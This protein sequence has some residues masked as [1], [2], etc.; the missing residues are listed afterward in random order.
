[1]FINPVRIECAQLKGEFLFEIF[2]AF[3][4]PVLEE[5]VG[6]ARS[7]FGVYIINITDW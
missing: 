6:V 4:V 2:A 7:H 5:E 3:C 1:M